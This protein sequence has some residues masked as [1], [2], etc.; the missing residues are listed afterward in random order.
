MSGQ[1]S[2][3]VEYRCILNSKEGDTLQDHKAYLLHTVSNLG[4]MKWRIIQ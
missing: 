1:V 4:Y 2:K 3:V